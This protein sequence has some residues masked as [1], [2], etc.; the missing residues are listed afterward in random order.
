VSIGG[1]AAQVI[2]AG[3]VPEFAGLS[4]INAAIPEGLAPR[5][6][7]VFITVN[8]VASNSGLITVK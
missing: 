5:D 8:G 1:N 3:V 7:P 6:Q 2:Y 4:Q